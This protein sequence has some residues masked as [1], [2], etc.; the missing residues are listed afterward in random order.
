MGLSCFLEYKLFQEGFHAHYPYVAITIRKIIWTRLFPR[1]D[2]F[3]ASKR[4][5]ASE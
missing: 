1:I 2:T 3:A 4:Q 5:R